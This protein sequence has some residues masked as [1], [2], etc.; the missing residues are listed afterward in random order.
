MNKNDVKILELI[1]RKEVNSRVDISN[2]LGISQ[3][4]VSKRVKYL[5]N[6]GY[7]KENYSKNKKTNGRNAV[8]LEINSNLG[9]V[10]GIYFAPE[11]IS[12]ALSDLEGNLLSLKKEKILE[13]KNIKKI[14]F[15]LIDEFVSKEN[16]I[17]IGIAMNGI[18]DVKNGVSIYS[19]AYNWNNIYIVDELKERYKISVTIENGVNLM[20]LY[21]KTF[22]MC[23]KQ[24]S[25][26]VINIGTG[27]GA[28]VYI[29]DKLYHGKDFGVGEIGHIPLDLSKEAL[30]C[31]CGSKGCI[32]TILS[33]WRIEKKIF[34]LT[35]KKY[36]YDEIIERANNGEIIFKN[37]FIELIPIFINMIFWITT[38]INP[39]DIVIYGKINKCGDFFWRELRRKVK[40]GNLNKNNNL[41]IKSA[42]FDSDTIVYG[43]VILALNTMFENN[44]K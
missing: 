30:I 8:G 32:E 14:C 24:K 38:L 2:K 42:S 3:A 11:E 12:I 41:N 25:F 28:G 19:A 17:K 27:V 26:V 13:N 16:I 18:V 34:N 33:D 1:Q 35:G 15:K 22:G 44:I 36:S 9:K 5:M 39:E 4:A 40:E 7:L 10:L 23:R 21:E 31:S 6:I 20:A 43:A 29:N 37:I